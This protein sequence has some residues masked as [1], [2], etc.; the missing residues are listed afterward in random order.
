MARIRELE[1]MIEAARDVDPVALTVQCRYLEHW[2]DIG[3]NEEQLVLIDWMTG[4]ARR[5]LSSPES[6]FGAI[7]DQ[8]GVSVMTG[9]AFDGGSS[10]PGRSAARTRDDNDG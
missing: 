9:P 2:L 1:T 6:T 10:A 7:L 3:S 5:S 8:D 4:S